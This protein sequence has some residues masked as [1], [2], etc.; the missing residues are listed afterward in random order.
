MEPERNARDYGYQRRCHSPFTAPS[1][2]IST[3]KELYSKSLV[4]MNSFKTA[5]FLAS[6]GYE[7]MAR[8]TDVEQ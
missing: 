4:D 5:I 7:T 6:E 8:E 3:I 2:T 1:E